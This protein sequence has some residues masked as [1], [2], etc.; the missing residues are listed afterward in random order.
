MDAL[1]RRDIAKSKRDPIVDQTQFTTALRRILVEFRTDKK[2]D[3]GKNAKQIGYRIAG[4]DPVKR[5]VLSF[6]VETGVIRL[7]VQQ[8]VVD[9]DAMK[10]L[11]LSMHALARLDEENA[12]KAYVSYCIWRGRK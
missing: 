2:G 12:N 10:D 6:L 8:Y 5:T 9:R 4:N 1:F 7:E 3:P 11:C